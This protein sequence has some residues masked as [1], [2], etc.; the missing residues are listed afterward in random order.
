MPRWIRTALVATLLGGSLALAGGCR[1]DLIDATP[2][3]VP[4]EDPGDDRLD[5]AVEDA[6][7][8]M[9]EDDAS[10]GSQVGEPEEAEPNASSEAA[11]ASR[12]ASREASQQPAPSR[13]ETEVAPA[14]PDT[15]AEAASAASSSATPPARERSAPQ[16]RADRREREGGFERSDDR[17]DVQRAGG[18]FNLL[19][20]HDAN[21][22]G[23]LQRSEIP[24]GFRERIMALDANGDGAVSREE[25]RAAMPQ[26][27]RRPE[28]EV[29]SPEERRARMIARLDADGDGRVT[30][31]ELPERLR[32]RFSGADA[33][34][35]GVLSVEELQQARETWSA[36]RQSGPA[37]RG[38][39]ESE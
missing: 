24:E 39:G 14:A 17:A 27:Q 11:P 32:E 3:N 16:E 8:E 22:D 28:G 31:D 25:L 29:V 36:R 37:G 20:Q 19:E 7:G 9:I 30:I 18:R 5:L 21:G 1:D 23:L 35:D 26:R 33:N 13:R 2:L 4:D 38:S 10:D 15:S 12:A 6:P 34:G